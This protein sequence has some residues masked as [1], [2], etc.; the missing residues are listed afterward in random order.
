MRRPGRNL[1]CSLIVCCF[2]TQAAVL[3]TL[4]N[5]SQVEAASESRDGSTEILTV[6][7]GTISLPATDIA[8]I[9][10]L[11]DP[12]EPAPSRTAPP[13]E[14]DASELLVSA[15][16]AQAVDSAFIAAVAKVESGLQQDAISKKGAIGLMQ[17][18]PGTAA[19]LGVKPE[20]PSE[21]ALGGAKYLRELL[22]RY[23][24]DARLALA[25][26]NAG[27]GAVE[28]Y[29]GVPPYPETIAYINRVLR[30]YHRTK[31][32]EAKPGGPVKPG[33]HPTEAKN[34]PDSGGPSGS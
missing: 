19:E 10:L 7:G 12:P 8:S 31:H 18:M 23:H 15:S 11:P 27:P 16:A 32:K 24:G 22:L 21:N 1:A 13:Q 33:S 14:P 34:G 20:R 3:V 17:L 6:G 28:R 25:A 5:G 9:D 2:S 4:K 30:E 26:Y 29:H